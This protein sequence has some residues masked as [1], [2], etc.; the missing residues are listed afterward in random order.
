MVLY[1]KFIC[2]HICSL[3]NESDTSANV[4]AG[5]GPTAFHITWKACHL[6][7]RPY[8]KNVVDEREMTKAQKTGEDK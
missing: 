1:I 2:A 3:P 6:C 8:D 5:F 4:G 7:Q